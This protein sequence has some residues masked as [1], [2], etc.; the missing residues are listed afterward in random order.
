MKTITCTVLTLPRMV[1]VSLPTKLEK[2]ID[3]LID[4]AADYG[5]SLTLKSGTS[6]NRD[7]STLEIST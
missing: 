5:V 7:D 4:A 3:L 2:G 1:D 6:T